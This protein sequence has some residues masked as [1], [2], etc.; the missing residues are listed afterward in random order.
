MKKNSA[1]R[2]HFKILIQSLG[3]TYKE[4]IIK[5]LI[6]SYHNLLETFDDTITG[7]RYSGIVKVVMAV[8]ITK[9]ESKEVC[10]R[11]VLYYISFMQF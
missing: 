11:S 3:L 6:Y 2:D 7:N 8:S 9:I 1:T 5:K 4:I 10:C